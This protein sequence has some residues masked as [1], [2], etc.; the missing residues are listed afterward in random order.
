MLDIQGYND[1]KNDGKTGSFTPDSSGSATVTLGFQP[2][3]VI[4]ISAASTSGNTIM[5]KDGSYLLRTHWTSSGGSNSDK[6]TIT[7]TST[8]FT[9]GQTS[10]WTKLTTYYYAC[11]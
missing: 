4:C 3:T 8:G 11:P 9:Y 10:N 6:L 7:P 5:Y 1:H 2:S